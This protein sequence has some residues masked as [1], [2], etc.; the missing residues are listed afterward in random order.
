MPASALMENQWNP[1]KLGDRS[2]GGYAISAYE[3]SSSWY[4]KQLNNIGDRKVKLQRYHD[5]DCSTI[6]IS[7]AL[8]IMSEDISSCN[9]D[10]EEPIVLEYPDDAAVLKSTLKLME[11][12]AE[13]WRKRSGMDDKLFDR[14]RNTL[15][16]GITF[17]LKQADGSLKEL[18]TEKM[19]GYVLD[20]EDEDNVTHYIYDETAP[21]IWDKTRQVRTRDLT[22]KEQTQY[23]PYAVSDLLIFKVGEGPFGESV[24]EKV[25]TV[26]KQMTLLEDA[27]IIYRVVR[28]PERRIYYIDVGNLQGPKREA[29]IEKQRLRLMQKQSNKKGQLSSEYDPHSTSEDIFIPTNSTGKGSRVETLQGGQNLGELSD[30]SYFSRKLASGLRI[31]HSMIDT[32][33]EQREQFSD[34]RVGQLY[35]IEMRYMGYIKRQKARFQ[36]PCND[37]FHEFCDRRGIIPPPGMELKIAD[38]MSFALYKEIELNQTMLN[39][40]N[41]TLQMQSMSRKYAFQKFLNMDHGEV[42][43]NEID[44]LMEL[45]LDEATIKTMAPHE[46]SNL[47]YGDK[48]LG[49][50]FGIQPV[51]GGGFGRF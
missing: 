16:Y 39:V 31:P 37:L 28:A 46:I 8:D 17:Y 44:K 23:Q 30:L 24:L 34:M 42:A 21:R 43:D 51:E 19:V 14:V 32:H 41:S 47:V 33:G 5:M 11:N 6:E 2:K 40:Y 3:T 20:P 25:Y 35:Q 4:N 27:I 49:E 13:V 26:W 50:K 7:R 45:G 9:A 1:I 48:R 38:S 18:H 10:D 15:K 36:A 12:A 29:A 22:R